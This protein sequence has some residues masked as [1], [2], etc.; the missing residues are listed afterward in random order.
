MNAEKCNTPAITFLTLGV[1]FRTIVRLLLIDLATPVN[2]GEDAVVN[3][4]LEK[5]F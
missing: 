3:Q 1:W 2:Q 5:L 4:I